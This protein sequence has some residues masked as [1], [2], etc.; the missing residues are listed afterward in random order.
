MLSNMAFKG[1]RGK[2][3]NYWPQNRNAKK[4]GVSIH[5][6]ADNTLLHMAFNPS[7]MKTALLDNLNS[8]PSLKYIVI[9]FKNLSCLPFS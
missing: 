5:L 2:L 9:Y 7:D 4:Y 8:A 3:K 6:Y 1:V